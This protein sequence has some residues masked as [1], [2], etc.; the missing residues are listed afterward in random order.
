MVHA[1]VGQYCIVLRVAIA[2]TVT[3]NLVHIL[4]GYAYDLTLLDNLG[5]FPHDGLYVLK[6]FHGNLQLSAKAGFRSGGGGGGGI[7]GQRFTRGCTPSNDSHFTI[8][9]SFRSTKPS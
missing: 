3:V 1:V 7:R 6:V 4:L 2:L 5:I 9:C 8:F